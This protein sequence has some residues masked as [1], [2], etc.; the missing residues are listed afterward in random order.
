MGTVS[1][2]LEA[3]THCVSPKIN[4]SFECPC[5]L[6]LGSEKTYMYQQDFLDHIALIQQA[7]SSRFIAFGPFMFLSPH[8]LE[9][10]LLRTYGLAI[11]TRHRLLLCLSCGSAVIPSQLKSHL[12]AKHAVKFSE[13]DRSTLL[14]L[15]SLC[16][17]KV[18]SLP[19][20]KEPLLHR[21]EGLPTIESYPC[22][23]CRT[24]GTTY[25][26]L[27]SHMRQKHKGTPY[28][29]QQVMV[30]IQP[31]HHASGRKQVRL[32]A[33]KEEVVR[34]SAKDI[35]SQASDMLTPEASASNGVAPVTDPRLLCP[36]LRKIRWQDLTIGKDIEELIMLVKF[37]TE[38]EY[39]PLLSLGLLHLLS[40]ASTKFDTTSELILQRLNTPK[41]GDE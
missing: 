36:W 17:I 34:F 19:L 9:S 18:S 38:E 30:S 20:L 33:Q 2:E 25:E 26:S 41:P 29:G 23:C 4:G 14:Q 1:F 15:L 10:P 32:Q 12:Y 5:P 39:G 16:H 6:H 28:P 21:I 37:P 8:L 7:I 40:L 27:K 35:L 31:L 24:V 22:P 3:A 11:E 13:D